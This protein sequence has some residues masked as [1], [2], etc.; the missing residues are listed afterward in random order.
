METGGWLSP[1][2]PLAPQLGV[3]TEVGLVG[4]EY[5]GP[6]PPGLLR[7]GGVFRHEGFP[8]LRISL[9]QP[10]LGALERE[11]QPVQ[12]VQASAAAQADTEALREELTHHLPV[13]VGEFDARLGGQLLYRCFQI[14]LLCFAE[15]GG[16]PL[17]CSKI[18][19]VG[20]PS[21]KAA[22]HLPMV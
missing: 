10:F 17:D 13:P 15:G 7:H 21:P 14:R 5:L 16:E 19:A 20:P 9:E 18:K 1:Q 11:S 3:H 12:I 4:E 22:A 2:H 6:G 8:F